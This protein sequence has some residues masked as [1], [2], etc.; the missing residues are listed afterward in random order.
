[1]T[2]ILCKVK[3]VSEAVRNGNLKHESIMTSN[4]MKA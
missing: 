4:V 2:D 3:L 1:M